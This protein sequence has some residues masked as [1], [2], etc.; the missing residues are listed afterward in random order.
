MSPADRGDAGP[1]LTGKDPGAEDQAIRQALLAL[2]ARLDQTNAAL[3]A[4]RTIDLV[5]LEDQAG[6]LCS[7]ATALPAAQAKALLPS[8]QAVLERLDR[9]KSLLE[10]HGQGGGAPAPTSAGTATR[11]RA[12]RAYGRV[13]GGEP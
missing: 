8:L 13:G 3:A 1:P 4:G 5:G 10:T 12:A 9:L 11:L 2:A 6:P 7:A